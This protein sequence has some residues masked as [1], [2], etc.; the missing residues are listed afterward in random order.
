M[1]INDL[2]L[3]FMF[4]HNMI[5]V[6]ILINKYSNKTIIVIHHFNFDKYL[7]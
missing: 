6:Y 2:F 5:I 3:L 1:I 4:T 7:T